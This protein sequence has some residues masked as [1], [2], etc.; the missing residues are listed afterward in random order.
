[1]SPVA[2]PALFE[3][4][5]RRLRTIASNL[6]LCHASVRAAFEAREFE[7]AYQPILRA[8]DLAP[9]A[10]EALLRWNHPVRGAQRPAQFVPILERSCLSLDVGDWLLE[11]AARQVQAWERDGLPGLRL[12]VNAARRQVHTDDF[13]DRTRRVLETVGLPPSRLT[14][15]I[16]QDVLLDQ[17]D[18][19]AS[20]IAQLVA[21][22][23]GL[24]LDDFGGGPSAVTRLKS[25]ALSGFKLD[26]R[27][28]DALD[29]REGAE[30]AEVKLMAELARDLGL[31]CT[32]E[33]VQTE[34]EFEALRELGV[35]E[36][37][38]YLFCAAMP[39]DALDGYLRAC[40][41]AVRVRGTV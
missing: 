1:M 7:I 16:S 24:E 34:D 26:R 35:S 33:G 19:S 11:T 17:P 3:G 25:C 6:P 41:D 22:G 8:S 37:Q 2:R 9:V 29:A 36:A 10:C 30:T 39:P 23:V 15:E 28:L 27:F 21:L 4:R 31:R 12:S 18:L 5:A 40:T 14:L 32:A 38:G 20:T 13:A